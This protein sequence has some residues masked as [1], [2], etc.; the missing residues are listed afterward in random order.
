MQLR[1]NHQVQQINHNGGACLVHCNAGSGEVKGP[2]SRDTPLIFAYVSARQRHRIHPCTHMGN[3]WWQEGSAPSRE[4]VADGLHANTY[5]KYEGEVNILP[6][7]P[8]VFALKQP[9]RLHCLDL[10][11]TGAWSIGVEWC[12]RPNRGLWVPD[13]HYIRGDQGASLPFE[14]WHPLC[15]LSC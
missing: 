14:M 2:F 7:Q 10:A 11:W 6:G 8:S 1:K 4:R 13:I 5:V 12:G 3:V 15:T 9:Q